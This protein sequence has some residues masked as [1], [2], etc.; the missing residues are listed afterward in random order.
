MYTSSCSALQDHNPRMTHTD[1]TDMTWEIVGVV[2]IERSWRSE[3][4]HKTLIA[5]FRFQFSF[6]EQ[7]FVLVSIMVAAVAMPPLNLSGMNVAPGLAPV[8]TLGGEV[9]YKLGGPDLLY[10]L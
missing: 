7:C 9:T 10:D 5:V 6:S 3:P 2:Q 4:H 8:D 1:M